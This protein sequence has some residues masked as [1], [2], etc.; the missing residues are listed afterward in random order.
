[1]N[2]AIDDFHFPS[3]FAHKLR[4]D[5]GVGVFVGESEGKHRY[6]FE[7]GGERTLAGGF[8]EMMRRVEKPNPDQQ[9][10]YARLRGVLAARDRD[11]SASPAKQ[12]T[13]SFLDQLASLHEKYPAGLAD[14]KWIVEVRGEGAEIRAPRHRQA[15]IQE[16][17]EKLSQ[18][19]LSS[20]LR[21]QHFAKLWEQGV[22][23][24]RHTDWV[25]ESQLKLKVVSVEH[26]RTLALAVRELLYGKA[27]F[28]A[29][30]DGYLAAIRA[31]FGQAA[32]WELATALSAL[33]HPTEHVCVDPT[34][35]RKQLKATS[36]RRSI[37]AQP[38]SV[39]YATCLSIARLIA[40][41][42]AEQGEVPRD[43]LEVRDFITFTLK[44]TPKGRTD[45][46]KGKTT[47]GL[48][49]DNHPEIVLTDQ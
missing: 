26:Q 38:S 22:A 34:T 21:A 5:W 18:E 30:F 6:L 4:S 45:R 42:L 16:A 36:S 49:P 32:R 8:H 1:M 3:L 14:P 9:A 24:L 37:P 13:C 23:V 12:G 20:L 43:L 25:P 19:A 40:N 11:G 17:Q 10:V 44:S 28:E 41:R 46:V 48:K 15:M 31:A 47:S 35:F 39:G 7:N 33:V 27:M 2:A 29:R